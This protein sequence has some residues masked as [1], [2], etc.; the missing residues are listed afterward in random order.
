MQWGFLNRVVQEETLRK[1]GEHLAHELLKG[2]KEAIRNTKLLLNTFTYPELE[3]EL[4]LAESFH[5]KAR[6]SKEA[7]KGINEFIR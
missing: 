2:S 3:Q 7:Q 1:E 4:S 5:L 6:E